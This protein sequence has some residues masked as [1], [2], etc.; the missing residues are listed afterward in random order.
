MIYSS[1]PVR[2]LQKV[3]EADR[4]SPGNRPGNKKTGEV[5]TEVGSDHH[6]LRKEGI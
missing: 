2:V 1:E 4:L 3:V 5:G 6:L